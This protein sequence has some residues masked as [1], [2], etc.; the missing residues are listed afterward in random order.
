[1]VSAVGTAAA[2]PR[3]SRARLNRRPKISLADDETARLRLAANARGLKPA[4]FM[5]H[6]ILEAIRGAETGLAAPGL[7][8]TRS[9]ASLPAGKVR[10]KLCLSESENA[11]VVK[12]AKAAGL[13]QQDYMR[14]CVL[15]ALT[16]QAPPKPKTSV[17]RN[18][19]AHEISMIAFQLKK[20]G[21]NLNQMSK[22]ANTGLVPITRNELV[23]FMNMHQRVLTLSV[24]SLEKVLG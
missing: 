11:L 5:R 19:L 12:A 8:G 24:A 3:S 17:S 2:A 4:Q 6:A 1:M 15:A 10:K 20:I 23:Y 18:A 21:T 9:D 14:H 22:Q 7:D 16:H 13:L